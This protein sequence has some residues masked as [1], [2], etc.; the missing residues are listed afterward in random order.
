[1]PLF[2]ILSNI[3]VP[4]R[5]AFIKRASAETAMILGKNQDFV[6]VVF[7]PNLDLVFSSTDKPALYV[8]L[9]SIGLPKN[10]IGE[11]AGKIMQFLENETRVSPS[12]MFIEFTDVQ[13]DLW[14]WNGDII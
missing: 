7:L 3:D 12:R 9:K 8:E 11:I 4:D 1:M 14:G 5:A 10:K 6:M 2:K 13:R